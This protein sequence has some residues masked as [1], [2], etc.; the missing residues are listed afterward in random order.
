[1]AQIQ[2]V[3]AQ[4][5]PLPINATATI[6]TDGPTMVTIAGSVWTTQTN[7]M[8][9]VQLAIDGQVVAKAQIYSNGPDT[10]RAVVPVT[11]SYTFPMGPRGPE[12]HEFTLFALTEQTTSD[13]ND[14][15]S[16]SVLY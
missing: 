4:A 9:G 13:F 2:Q 1:M 3:I 11:I 14:F 15:F 10:H 7:S 16:V 8:I 12:P 5:G 6:S